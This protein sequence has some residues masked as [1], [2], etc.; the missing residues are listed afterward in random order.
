MSIKNLTSC[1]NIPIL[2]DTKNQGYNAK[3]AKTPKKYLRQFRKT[4]EEF[5]IPLKTVENW[6]PGK[7]DHKKAEGDN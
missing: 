5:G 4:A 7:K 6:V 3:E 2:V 1:V